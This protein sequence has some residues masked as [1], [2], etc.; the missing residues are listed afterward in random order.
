MTKLIVEDIHTI[1]TFQKS[2][3]LCS[4]IK[5]IL[6]YKPESKVHFWEKGLDFSLFVL[7]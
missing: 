1:Q 4:W 7:V 6:S 5:R 2:V 3:I